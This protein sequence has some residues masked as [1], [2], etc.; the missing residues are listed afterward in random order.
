[1][2]RESLVILSIFAGIVLLFLVLGIREKRRWQ[3]S[4]KKRI[5]RESG[6]FGKGSVPAEHMSRILKYHEKHKPDGTIAGLDDITWADLD[7]DRVFAKWN[8]TYSGA[9]EEVLYHTLRTPLFDTDSIC[10]RDREISYFCE[11]KAERLE[12]QFALALCGGKDNISLY[13]YL[14]D[15]EDVPDRGSSNREKRHTS[16]LASLRSH[17]IAP[18]LLIIATAILF[19]H[20]QTGI[21]ALILVLIINMSWYFS[22]R[23]KILPYLETIRRVCAE[24]AGGHEILVRKDAIFK[25]DLFNE[26]IAALEK[27]TSGLSGF[28]RGAVWV[29]AGDAGSSSPLAV[30]KDYINMVL[31]IDLVVF[32]GLGMKLRKHVKDVDSIHTGIGYLEMLCAAASLRDA[33]PSVCRPVFDDKESAENIYH[34]LINDPVKNSYELDKGM[35][36]TGSN[37]SG[38][39]TFLKT[40]AINMIMAQT[41][42]IACAD[43]F[44]TGIH[45]IFTS[46]AIKDDLAAKESY[47]MAEIRAMKRIIS[48]SDNDIKIACFVDEVLRGTNTIERIAASSVILEYMASNGIF[49][50][51]ATH[52]IE[53]ASLLKDSYE[54]YHFE[55][56]VEGDE[57]KF[58]Y[59]LNKGKAVS[60]NAI[61]LLKVMG[62]EDDI[63]D[64][65]TKRAEGFDKNGTWT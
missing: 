40:V 54:N 53:L 23:P 2:D 45:R 30:I 58:N 55:E 42:N 63:V 5:E 36:L 3:R 64:K 29:I 35:L 1:M 33:L 32:A 38:K 21:F 46:M 4:L 19:I 10:N 50:I 11:H 59:I 61:R 49:C 39:S 13:E 41:F 28:S 43:S 51:A 47:F 44:H 14:D 65:A 15:F 18:I 17:I 7:M 9:G 34:P 26:R 20:V 12:L 48:N 57:V 62:Y 52:D 27:L 24:L 25:D 8:V 56:S 37:A 22:S 16:D 6:K 31:H 60:R